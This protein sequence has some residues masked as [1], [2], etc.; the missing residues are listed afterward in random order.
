MINDDA[1]LKAEFP[2]KPQSSSGG[3]TGYSVE[4]RVAEHA[5]PIE[6]G[7]Q[8]IVKKWKPVRFPEAPIGVP[9]GP[10]YEK[11]REH[12]G[13]L[14]YPA[15][16]AL[17]WWLHA[18]V[19]ARTFAFGLGLE[20]RLIQHNITYSFEATPISEHGHIHGADR[21]NCIP[22]WGKTQP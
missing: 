6:V 22:D 13:L 10:S 7:G 4:A 8:L 19:D 21:S 20:T 15:A 1:Q 3:Q 9:A 16:Q 2:R 14:S 17:R 12:F 18:Q 5:D 11:A